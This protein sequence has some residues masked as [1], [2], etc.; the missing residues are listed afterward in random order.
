MVNKTNANDLHGF[1]M[2]ISTPF[3]GLLRG[4]PTRQVFRVQILD[5]GNSLVKFEGTNVDKRLEMDLEFILVT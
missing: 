2:V 5:L 4:N 3:S 1:G